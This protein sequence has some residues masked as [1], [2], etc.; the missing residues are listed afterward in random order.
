MRLL[1]PKY[2]SKEYRETTKWK[3][4]KKE[5]R[6]H[7]K[8]PIEFLKFHRGTMWNKW[9]AR[10]RYVQIFQ[11]FQNSKIPNSLTQKSSHQTKVQKIVVQI[12]QVTRSIY[13]ITIPITYVSFFQI[14][15]CSCRIVFS[16]F[17]QF[18][19]KSYRSMIKLK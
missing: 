7:N 16:N 6:L 1:F 17:S 18:W 9:N 3:K 4:K 19:S 14:F 11:K 8:W 13:P 5:S 15:I 10:N 12:N 2:S